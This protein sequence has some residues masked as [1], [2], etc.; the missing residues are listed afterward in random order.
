ML[1]QVGRYEVPFLAYTSRCQQPS[2]CLPRLP[3]M[4]KRH[5]KQAVKVPASAPEA[6]DAGPR[7]V[8]LPPGLPKHPTYEYY[9]ELADVALGLG[10][11]EPKRTRLFRKPVRKE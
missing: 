6:R 9:L 2:S 4:S 3:A 11:P 10:K 1:A 8:P 5:S 7:L